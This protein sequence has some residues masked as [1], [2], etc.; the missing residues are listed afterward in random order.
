ML[1]CEELTERASDYLERQLSLA[2]KLDIHLH[3]RRC[4]GCRTYLRQME[5][6]VRLLRQ[7]PD[8]PSS[9]DV[10]AELWARFHR[11]PGALRLVV[12]DRATV[13]ARAA[14]KEAP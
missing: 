3:L 10:S 1:S 5:E 11:A 4:R 14:F 12:A 2:Q 8:P 9:A 13:G 6:T 7:L